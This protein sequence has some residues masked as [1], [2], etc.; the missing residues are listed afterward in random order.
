MMAR[1]MTLQSVDRPRTLVEQVYERVLDAI[2]DGT[3]GPEQHITQDGLATSLKVSRQPVMT[4]L[5]QLKQQGFLIE[6]GRRGLRI[7]PIEDARLASILEMRTVA[8]PLAA[9]L[10]A[11]RATASDVASGRAILERGQRATAAG[12][13]LEATRAETDFHEWLYAASG[14][15]VL[16]QAMQVHWPHVRRAAVASGRRN[17]SPPQVWDARQSALN[18]IERGD[19]PVAARITR[20]LLMDHPDLAP[21][22]EIAPGVGA[23]TGLLPS[24]A[25]TVY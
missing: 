5:G 13:R 10:A 12:L 24:L 22:P 15:P 3:L 6:R 17:P 25:H 9:A 14:N 4:A 18:A 19:A 2:C 20:Q 11:A 7:A 8:E 1:H 16:A 21:D 23:D